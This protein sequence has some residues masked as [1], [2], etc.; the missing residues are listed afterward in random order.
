MKNCPNN[1]IVNKIVGVTAASA[2]PINHQQT[3]HFSLITNPAVAAAAAA[4]NPLTAAA[5]NLNNSLISA[6]PIR[7]NT[8]NAIILAA[9]QQHPAALHQH[10]FGAPT[11]HLIAT[12]TNPSITP[13]AAA[14]TA[15]KLYHHQP[16][17][18]VV[19]S[20]LA[21]NSSNSTAS[22]CN[23]QAANTCQLPVRTITAVVGAMTTVATL[24][25]TAATTVL[26]PSSATANGIVPQSNGS[27]N[28]SNNNC[29]S[30]SNSIAATVAAII[31]NNLNFKY[32]S[33]SGNINSS[34]V[35][36]NTGMKVPVNSSSNKHISSIEPNNLKHKLNDENDKFHPT[37]GVEG[38]PVCKK[39][40]IDSGSSNVA[41]S[42]DESCHLPEEAV[43]TST[44]SMAGTTTI[45]TT[46][47]SN[48]ER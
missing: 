36:Q 26:T 48:Q 45:T 17:A 21:P 43:A 46:N 42:T 47:D 9:H 5:A 31:N 16:T 13:I 35:L 6:P 30:S 28:S 33:N 19:N 12:P 41:S 23:L 4:A 8:N 38:S 25:S 39:K 29:N 34:N 1:S 22:L 10:P 24:A 32:S 15:A 20:I 7:T 3:A 37:N 11:H 2:A 40:A 44:T 18:T 27:N 14:A